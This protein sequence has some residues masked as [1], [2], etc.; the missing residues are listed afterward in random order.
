M[1]AGRSSVE[2]NTDQFRV[3][4]HDVVGQGLSVDFLWRRCPVLGLLRR[5][6]GGGAR[7]WG[8]GG[9]WRPQ[10]GRGK[11]PRKEEQ[12]V[13]WIIS[14]WGGGGRVWRGVFWYAEVV[15]TR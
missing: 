3:G 7:V 6:W 15:V 5:G 2:S 13:L 10:G 9:G 8:R 14:F 12:R 4:G 1:L 11:Y